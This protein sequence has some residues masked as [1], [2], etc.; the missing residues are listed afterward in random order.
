MFFTL[1][2][3]F[4]IVTK[5]AHIL[6]IA[7]CLIAL[8]LWFKCYR[9][10]R[11]LATLTAVVMLFITTVHVSPLIIHVLEY[12]FPPPKTLPA[13]VD[14]MVV[15]GGSI[16]PN[17]SK[18]RDHAQFSDSIERIYEAVA[19][20]RRYPDARIVFTGGAGAWDAAH[21]KEAHFA[22]KVFADLGV[23]PHK[24]EFED[25]SRNT[26]ENAVFAKQL[27][28]PMANETWLLVTSAFHMPRAMGA[29]R[30]A[31]WEVMPYPVY[32][33]TGETVEL[34][35]MFHM[36]KGLGGISHVLHEWLGLFFYWITDR[37]D[38][39]FPAPRENAAKP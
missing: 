11:F 26:S 34:R 22:A 5:P 14:G 15:L 29:F 19:L 23:D 31:G 28:K 25:R 13:R 36:I 24:V 2:K 17:L 16:D 32:F 4:W 3:I 39:L 30:K 7:V 37:S 12:R 21:L 18:A 9:A 1:S 20:S 8:L 35:L 27:A 10:A 6:V 38:E 33:R